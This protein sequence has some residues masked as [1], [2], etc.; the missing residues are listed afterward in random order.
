MGL[1]LWQ[2]PSLRKTR[3]RW[4]LHQPAIARLRMG[5]KR[6]QSDPL[7]GKSRKRHVAEQLPSARKGL[8]RLESRSEGPVVAIL[9]YAYLVFVVTVINGLSVFNGLKLVT[10]KW[11]AQ[12]Q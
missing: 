8:G 3:R 11:A 7:P 2:Q 10:Q 6:R 12:C 9:F 4:K 1:P 5:S